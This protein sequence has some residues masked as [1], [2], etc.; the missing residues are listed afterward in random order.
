MTVRIGTRRSRLALAQT[1]MVSSALK[2]CF[3][4]LT[5]EFVEIVTHGDRVLDKP[6]DRIGGKGVFVEE[7]EQ[8]LRAGEIDMAVHSAK[9]LPVQLG[10][11][12]EI[13][14]V[15]PRG[16]SRDML[17]TRSGEM[18][19]SGAVFT[20]GTGSL[21][22]RRNFTALYPNA[23]FRDIRGNV[24]TRLRRLADGEYDGIVLCCAGIKRLGLS[25]PGF[26]VREFGCREF[27]PAPCQG[28]IAVEC[29]A[30]SGAAELARGISD[31]ETAL[32]FA[33]EREIIAALGADCT[34]PVGAF[35]EI[36]GGTMDIV[37]S[38]S[39]GKTVTGSCAPEDHSQKI[40]EMTA[41]L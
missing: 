2:G 20:V 14:G 13:S 3:P 35:T 6:L 8:A 22:R 24:D 21:R 12:L 4:E 39:T 26:S 1:A 29:A 28:I 27:I 19:E 25:L 37:I 36:H 30:G 34:V 5:V 9:D 33:A 18:P 16:D 17:I 31:P 41:G 23:V 10:E 15:L 38:G 7:I 32:C 11:G 40:K